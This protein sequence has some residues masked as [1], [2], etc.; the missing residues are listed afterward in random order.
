[1]YYTQTRERM[2]PLGPPVL[3]A[4]GRVGRQIAQNRSDKPVYLDSEHKLV[5]LHGE[6]APTLTA[7]LAAERTDRSYIRPSGCDCTNIDGLMSEY[8]YDPTDDPNLPSSLYE[9]LGALGAEQKTV[10][11]RPQRKAFASAE[12]EVWVQPIGTIV[13]AHGNTRKMVERMIN[14]DAS[15]RFRCKSIQHCRCKLYIPRRNGSVFASTPKRVLHAKHGVARGPE[16]SALSGGAA[17]EVGDEI[18]A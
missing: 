6:R 16:I 11:S 2:P 5:C 3:L 18:A 14:A 13:C 7:W 12:S 9:L 4:S 10:M 1:M 15:T 8:A 17:A